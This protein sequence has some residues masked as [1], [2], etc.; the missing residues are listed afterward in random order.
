MKRAVSS[1]ILLMAFV[2]GTAFLAWWTVP[3]VAGVWGLMATYTLKPWRSAAAAAAL[4]WALLLAV[5]GTRGPLLELAG[6]LGGIF[7]LPGFAVVLLTLAF[8]ALLAWSAAGL[9]SALRAVLT[10][11]ARAADTVTPG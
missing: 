7:G 3:I 9:V 5:S 10:Q 4:A 1:A 6:L 11:R 2:L 8:P